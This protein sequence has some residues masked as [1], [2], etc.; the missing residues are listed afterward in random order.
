MK[1]IPTILTDNGELALQQIQ[2]LRGVAEWLQI[3]VMDGTMT[4]NSTFDLYDLVGELDDFQI[5]IHLM[6]DN[7]ENYFEACETLGVQRVYFH[8]E[9]V[10]SPSS[11]L[12]EMNKFS[13]TKGIVLSPQTEIKAIIPYLTDIQAVQIM[14]VVPGKQGQKFMSSILPKIEKFKKDYSEI[15]LSV[16]GGVKKQHLKQLKNLGVDAVGVG[17]AIMNTK[18]LAET[19]QEFVNFIK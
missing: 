4:Q 8:F 5:E 13:F 12:A 2:A 17:S 9:A 1:I 10:E 19:F 14:T 18:N 6:V 7:P 16:D 11:I 15:W 3:D